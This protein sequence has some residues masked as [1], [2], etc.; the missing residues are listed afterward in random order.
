MIPEEQSSGPLHVPSSLPQKS[1]S[2]EQVSIPPEVPETPAD[3]F[4]P[5]LAVSLDVPPIN[6]P[7]EDPGTPTPTNVPV[8]EAKEDHVETSRNGS[9]TISGS[10]EDQVSRQDPETAKKRQNALTRILW[11][12]IMIGGFVGNYQRTRCSSAFIHS[13]FM[14]VSCSLDMPT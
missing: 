5:G 13:F 10:S 9:A 8:P 4:V 7:A 1:S 2:L 3:K 11:T 6:V 12:F 14:Q